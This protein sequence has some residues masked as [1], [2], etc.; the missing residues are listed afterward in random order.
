MNWRSSKIKNQRFLHREERNS[1]S[2]S[3][4]KNIASVAAGC[5]QEWMVV[6]ERRQCGA[7]TKKG[8]RCKNSALKGQHVCHVHHQQASSTGKRKEQSQARTQESN[9][10]AHVQKMVKGTNKAHYSHGNIYVFTYAHMMHPQPTKTPY[11]HLAEPT[12]NRWIDYSRTSPF[13]PEEKILL[14]VGY[15]RKKPETR[16]QEWREQCGHSEFVLL[17]PGCLVPLYKKSNSARDLPRVR[18]NVAFDAAPAEQKISLLASLMRKLHISKYEKSHRHNS[19]NRD[20]DSYISGSVNAGKRSHTG[21][22]YAHLNATKTCFVTR[23]PYQVEQ[24]IHKLLRERYGSGKMYCHG[25]A[26]THEDMYRK[27]VTVTGVHTEWFLIPRVEMEVVW[28]LIESQ[29]S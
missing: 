10:T 29:C 15:T 12:D 26:K 11:L 20:R 1:C 3:G 27:Q 6:H 14:K 28:A 25:C 4:L 2:P 21:R 17:Y 13:N 19:F 18:P 7:L 23:E 22:N 16:V 8:Q 24:K 9:N 5:C